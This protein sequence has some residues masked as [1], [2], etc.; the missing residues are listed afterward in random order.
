V[1]FHLYRLLAP[2]ADTVL[3]YNVDVFSWSLIELLCVV[4]CGSI[5]ALRPLLAI[6]LSTIT[7]SLS[8]TRQR[9]ERAASQSQK[10]GMDSYS[11]HSA[12]MPKRQGSASYSMSSLTPTD[13]ASEWK[14]AM[15]GSLAS[16]H[17]AVHARSLSAKD[18]RPAY[19]VN[20]SRHSASGSEDDLVSSIKR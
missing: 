6:S 16:Y 20:N 17:V 5:P 18:I 2:G 14:K 7:S 15:D 3:V 11:R 12:A 4:V 19:I 1:A 8:S 10:S 13:P 9:S